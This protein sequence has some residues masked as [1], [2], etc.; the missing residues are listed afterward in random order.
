M[1]TG[2]VRDQVTVEADGSISLPEHIRESGALKAGDRLTVWWLPPDEIVLRKV[3]PEAD[4]DE[5]A[6]AMEEFR[7]DLASAGYDTKEKINRLVRQ[8]KEEQ[9]REW[10]QRGPSE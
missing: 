6:S 8:I 7:T 2:P 1:S 9:A 10:M 3:T 4:R 5:F